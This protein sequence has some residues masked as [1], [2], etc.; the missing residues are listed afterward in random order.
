MGIQKLEF[1]ENGKSFLDGI[2]SIF[3]NYLRVSFD[4]K[5]EKQLTQALKLYVTLHTKMKLN[6]TT[7]KVINEDF[8]TRKVF[9]VE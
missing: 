6:K 9:C 7:E 4:V 5:M 3:H 1:P 8:S 2:K